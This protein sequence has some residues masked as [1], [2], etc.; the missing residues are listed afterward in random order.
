M[1]KG[2]GDWLGE[3]AQQ[4]RDWT[5]GKY[6]QGKQ[7]VKD[8]ADEIDIATDFIPVVGQVKD[9]FYTI[10][11]G[12]A[13][14]KNPNEDNLVEFG[15][16]LIGWVPY[17]GDTLKGA[18]KIAR[19]NPEQLLTTARYAMKKLGKQGDPEQF[20]YDLISVGSLNSRLDYVY[21]LVDR[22]LQGKWGADIMRKQLSNMVSQ[23]KSLLTRVSAAMRRY[24]N[25]VLPHAPKTSARVS[26]P[27]PKPKT[28]VRPPP[29]KRDASR[30][31]YAKS[32]SQTAK[33]GTNKDDAGSG[34]SHNRTI[35]TVLD[36][37][38]TGI[39]G[40][41]MGD[42]WVAKELGYAVHHDEGRSYPFKL[43]GPM[44][45]LN[46]TARGTG[47]DSLW[48]TN[49]KPLGRVPTKQ[50]AKTLYTFDR[51]HAV[52]E[53][54]ASSS[55][56][57]KSLGSVLGKNKGRKATA[58]KSPQ[59]V[60]GGKSQT[61]QNDGDENYQMSEAWNNKK[62]QGKHDDV[63]GQYSRHVLFFGAAAIAEHSVAL[64]KNPKAPNE[65]EHRHHHAT[66]LAN[67]SDIDQTISDKKERARKR[68]KK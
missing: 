11:Y 35:D 16:A 60:K 15:F 10:K 58:G 50:F 22:A 3:K 45:V 56:G 42:Y 28:A 31:T 37:A 41:H 12:W 9:A 47:I 4:T 39:I 51:E 20:L 54:K 62:L 66:W 1:S 44:T 48:L 64:T 26:T 61:T 67:G 13:V 24:L 7:W 6:N 27:T 40:E 19:K 32:K 68:G 43:D 14:Y 57:H 23:I 38:L 17:A 18:F 53:Y 49:H 46:G 34:K 63:I 36:K 21:A 55:K 33:K 29:P 8:H 30:V 5:A 65:A 25:K 59:K 2:L 52:V